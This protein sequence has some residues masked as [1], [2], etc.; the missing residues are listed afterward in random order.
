MKSLALANGYMYNSEAWKYVDSLAS[1]FSFEKSGM[2]GIAAEADEI[3]YFGDS[4]F[5]L[6][7]T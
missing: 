7:D 5:L 4:S 2:H 6:R 1:R 3:L